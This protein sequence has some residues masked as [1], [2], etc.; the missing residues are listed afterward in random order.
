L[1]LRGAAP[2]VDIVVSS[3]AARCLETARLLFPGHEPEQDARMREIDVGRFEGVLES[4]AASSMPDLY[5]AWREAPH[6][7]R[8]GGT[9][10]TLLE[11]SA[12]VFAA[13]VERRDRARES[14]KRI[15]IV[16]HG[17]PI[18]ALTCLLARRPL[19]DFH[20]VTV[21]NLAFFAVAPDFSR[22]DAL[23]CP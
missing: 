10:E 17:G 23:A 1:A 7:C 12:R 15:C 18:R 16:T 11:L 13:L 4:D 8:V 22:I 19:A 9:G 20:R 14:G 3:P 6:L 5:A 2:D 21:D